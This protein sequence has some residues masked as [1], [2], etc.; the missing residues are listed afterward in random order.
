MG[1]R[2]AEALQRT[3]DRNLASI[4][5][6]TTGAGVANRQ[7]RHSGTDLR[8]RAGG[9]SPGIR[10]FAV[11]PYEALVLAVLWVGVLGFFSYITLKTIRIMVWPTLVRGILQRVDK[12][13]ASADRMFWIEVS[14][15]RHRIRNDRDLSSRLDTVDVLGKPVDIR[16]GV[17]DRVL[18]VDVVQEQGHRGA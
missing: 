14:G 10:T 3:W 2:C 7:L 13:S 12:A 16:I 6:Q 1:C 5:L 15:S 11:R 8:A 18:S 4:L 17:G 9:R